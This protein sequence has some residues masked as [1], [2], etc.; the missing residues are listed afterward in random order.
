M[1]L[2]MKRK[3]IPSICAAVILI[4]ALTVSAAAA[5]GSIADEMAA[6]SAAWWIA[7]ENGDQETMDA[8]HAANEELASQLAGDSGDSSYNSEK[9]TWDITT[10]DGDHVSSSGSGSYKDKEISYTTTDDDGNE[11]YS[12]S[13]V[14]SDD[15]I[16][17]YIDNG[18]TN[19]GLV[20]SYNSLGYKESQYG[21][22]VDDPDNLSAEFE[23]NI[24]QQVLGLTDEEAADLQYKLEK[25]KADYETAHDAYNAAKARGDEAGMA[26]AQAAMDAAHDSAEAA[27]GEY[28]YS[29]DSRASED[30]GYFYDEY[31]NLLPT[32]GGGFFIIDDDED[33]YIY[34]S[35]GTGGDI[36][37]YG[38]V[39]V[40]YYGS[41]SFTITPHD[42][43]S[44]ARVVVDGYN[45]G[46]VSSYSFRS[47]T[48]SHS[49]SATF[50]RNNRNMTITASAGTGG[51]IS[52]A[53]P[54]TV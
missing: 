44:I 42:G 31:G 15:S 36:S 26:A 12:S 27:R 28:N 45:V 29:A 51:S 22:A 40:G 32:S 52:P 6:N 49:I 54:S 21:I 17:S 13:Y 1:K 34:A 16:D 3:S 33:I 18:G 5:G 50:S 48:S 20:N 47:V 39:Y 37:P 35:A 2:T 7:K 11:D 25:S 9:G 38:K 8:L 4:A 46:A 43:Y 19:D 41:K 14:F 53:G 30:G 24:A 23:I 10:D